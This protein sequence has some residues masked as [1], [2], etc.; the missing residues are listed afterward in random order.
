MKFKIIC[1][2]SFVPE[3]PDLMKKI[4]DQNNFQ[5]NFLKPEAIG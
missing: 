1:T 2:T 3:I 5:R 4:D